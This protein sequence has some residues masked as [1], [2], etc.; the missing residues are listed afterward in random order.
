MFIS[1]TLFSK[2]F[3][4]FVA[5]ISLCGISLLANLFLIYLACNQ[6]TRRAV[7]TYRR[8]EQELLFS[9]DD[10]DDDALWYRANNILTLLLFTKLTIYFL[11]GQECTVNCQ[12]QC[13]WRHLAADYTIAIS[14]SLQL[15][16]I[17]PTLTLIIP[18]PITVCNMSILIAVKMC[19]CMI[20]VFIF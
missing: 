10:D 15:W 11:I 20:A 17:T 9:A 7:W 2:L 3:V 1:F 4:W 8:G 14:L 19:C 6:A 12:N 18:H 13:Q 5:V 16:P